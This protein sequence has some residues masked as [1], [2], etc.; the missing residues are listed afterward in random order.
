VV[1]YG[2]PA[3]ARGPQRGDVAA[4]SSEKKP[5]IHTLLER[6]RSAALAVRQSKSK[7]AEAIRQALASIYHLHLCSLSDPAVKQ[8]L[9]LE[10]KKAKI[11]RSKNTTTEFTRLIKLPFGKHLSR[12]TVSRWAN[13]LQLALEK[14]KP[15]DLE[16]FVRKNGGTAACARL[17]PQQR[18]EAAEG[19]AKNPQS[20]AM[21]MIKERLVDAPKIKLPKGLGGGKDVLELLVRLQA[22][23][24]SR[25]VLAASKAPVCTA[26]REEGRDVGGDVREF[27]EFSSA[28]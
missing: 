10:C 5:D 23:T 6:C 21:R 11:K 12:L 17:L 14:E 28:W 20:A 24:N 8:A 19:V 9:E 2:Q 7:F 13:T 18:G 1:E 16:A 3:T 26:W 25:R 15:Q 22:A 4:P 27:A